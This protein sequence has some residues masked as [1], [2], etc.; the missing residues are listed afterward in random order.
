MDLHLGEETAVASLILSM[1]REHFVE[2]ALV[3]SLELKCR[4]YT[5]LNTFSL[6][7][8]V[9]L[10]DELVSPRGEMQNYCL[11]LYS[12]LKGILE[13]VKYIFSGVNSTVVGE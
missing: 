8:E 4:N 3:A 2:A 11:H 5:N 6:L 12:Q 1:D 7:S 13:I 10:P 9:K